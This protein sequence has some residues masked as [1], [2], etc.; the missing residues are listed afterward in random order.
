MHSAIPS[1][2]RAVL[3]GLRN[4]LRKPRTVIFN[5]ILESRSGAHL[6]VFAEQEKRLI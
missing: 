5:E 2:E 1:I 3:P 4:E 6:F